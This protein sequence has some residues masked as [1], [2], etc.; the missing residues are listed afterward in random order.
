MQ[1]DYAPILERCCGID[2]PS[3]FENCGPEYSAV[4]VT[5]VEGGYPVAL[6]RVESQR[7]SAHLTSKLFDNYDDSPVI[8]E[9]DISDSEWMTLVKL[10]ETS[11]FW[12]F[13]KRHTSWRPGAPSLWVEACVKGQFRSIY[14]YPDLNSQ[15]AEV[16]DFLVKLRN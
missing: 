16:V 13:D 5:E 15:L 10:L 9:T 14:I 1:M 11:G 2:E 12:T 6:I 7:D 3:I 8:V 4:R